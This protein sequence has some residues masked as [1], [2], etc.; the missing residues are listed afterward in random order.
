MKKTKFVALALVVALVLAG[1]AYAWWGETLTM[2]Q[3]VKTG[4]LNVVFSDAYTRGGDNTTNEEDYDVPGSG[5]PGWVEHE[6]QKYSQLNLN[7][8]PTKIKNKGDRVIAEIGNM[9]PGSRGQFEFEIKNTGTI[10][11]VFES[12]LSDITDN[13]DPD[14]V[15]KLTVVAGV[16]KGDYVNWENGQAINMTRILADLYDGVRLDPQETAK[17]QIFIYFDK[18]GSLTEGDE[19]EKDKLVFDLT[20]DWTQFNK[21]PDTSGQ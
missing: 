7:Y 21:E 20:M 18:D 5:Y 2:S 11:A 8:V 6:G 12:A 1:T 16:K 13:N 14:L 10:P 9:Y 17:T 3:T 15:S 4:E 19:N